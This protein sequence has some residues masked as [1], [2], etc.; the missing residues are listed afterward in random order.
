MENLEII[1]LLL[2]GVTIL[3][4]LSYRYNF[5]F[6]IVLVLAGLTISFIPGL[7]LVTLKPEIVFLIFLPPLLY[8]AAWNTSWHDFK[9]NIRSISLAAI[10]LVFFTT[11]LV[12]VVAHYVIP[13]LSWAHAF[14]LG[15]IV[16]PPDALAATSVTKGLG[17]NPRIIAILEGESLVNDASGLIAYKYALAAIISGTFGVLDAGLQFVWVIVA[18]IGIGLLIGYIM[19][20]VHH[21]FVCDSIIETTLTFLTPFASY[22]IAE[23]FHVSGVL[24]VV[25]T[26][27]Y[28]SF[29][30]GE[31]F[32]TQ[33]RI[34]TYAVWDVV[35]FILNGLIFILLGLQLKYVISGIE[36]GSL[37]QLIIYGLIVSLVVVIVRFIW[38]VPAATLPRILSKRI[39][40]T[41]TFDRRNLVIFGWAGMRGV[42]SMAAALSIPLL[43]DSGE[44]FP[45][46]NL[47]IFLTFSVIIFTLLVQ[48]L[49]L[50]WVIRRLKLPKHSIVEE[51]YQVRMKMI[52]A[53]IT[54]IEENLSLT[55]DDLLTKIKNKYEIKYNRLQHTELP[56]GFL[57]KHGN[58]V[59][60]I[61]NRFTGI[62]LE[63]LTI[64]RDVIKMLHR[65]GGASEEV[66]RKIEHEL[67]LEE[68]RLQMDLYKS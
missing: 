19:F 42:V 68:S 2:F 10:G 1:V 37:I 46:R 60:E 32:S 44:A 21:R 8:G 38:V 15:A 9:A 29:Q 65:Q 36:D 40:T 23:H 67:D 66:L 50:P 33:S 27:L 4:L 13:D 51:E 52:A 59:E 24:A 3:A 34:Q 58:P 63:L 6:P 14:L 35:V 7:P 20:Q 62:E 53:S 43:T 25:T 56:E 30:S 31:I 49:T 39:R 54:H 55:E 45:N 16:S 57:E 26:G 48:G 17:L 18:G 22:L 5:P 41:E 11:G 28:L 47:I 12:G 61:F 64:E